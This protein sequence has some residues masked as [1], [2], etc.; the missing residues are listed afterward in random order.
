MAKRTVRP[1]VE[2]L[3]RYMKTALKC[4]TLL[5]TL[6]WSSWA[7]LNVPL[8]VREA[9]Y[10]GSM[11]GAAR[12]D[13]PFTLGVP[14]PDS[15]GIA[16]TSVF[17]LTGA[18]A[19]QF[20]VEARWPSGNIKWL[21]V[22]ATV[23]SFNAG[24][25]ATVTLTDSGTGDFGGTGLAT[26][27][28][29]TITVATGS[30]TFKI[31]KANFNVVD[32]VDVGATH[33]VVSGSSQGI[34]LQGPDPAATYPGNVTCLPTAG[35]SACTTLYKSS[36]DTKSTCSIEENGPSISALKCTGDLVDGASHVY[37]HHTTRLFFYKNKNYVKA[38]V[39]LR[40]ADYGT[41]NTFASATKGYQG[42][43]LRV[44]PNISGALN[45]TIANHTATPTTGKLNSTGGTDYA[46]LY[47][48][49]STLMKPAGWCGSSGCVTPSPLSG[50]SI[51]A[52][53]SAVTTGTSGQYPAGM[54]RYQRCL[55][56]RRRDRAVPACRVWQ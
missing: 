49:E 10:P 3:Y 48:A 22:R 45:Y 36:N 2:D 40:N 54:G 12:I 37:M 9:L 50:Y 39:A 8:T 20:M 1:P 15:A 56:R 35:G 55:R 41:S 17:G 11:T 4:S 6:A 34:V 46:Y 16:S 33:V 32:A 53:G 7:A 19:G 14:I 24:G 28:G 5:F 44:S 52:N 38:T 43:E 26:D 47:Q 51:V 30:A 27:N 23:S 25:T 29:S 18:T 42:L 21:K 13:E 31:N